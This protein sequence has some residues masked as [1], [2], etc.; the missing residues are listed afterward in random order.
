VTP[1]MP[2]ERPGPAGV[3]EALERAASILETAPRVAIACHVNPDPDAIG[4]MLGLA[5]ALRTRGTEV[6]CSWANDP[7][8][9]PAWLDL[10]GDVAP[11]V[12]AREF[13]SAPELMVTCDAASADRLGSLVASADRAGE[14][15]VIDHHVTNPGFGSVNLID[16]HAASS[17]E[18]VF[19]VVERMGLAL[20]DQT[21]A[22][23][24]AGVVTD[25]GRFQY[26]ATTGETLRVAAHLRDHGFDHARLAHALFEDGSFAGL[27][28]LSVALARAELV[29]DTRLGLVWTYLT[30]EDLA[31][32]GVSITETDDVIDVIRTAREA[33]VACVLKQQRD[34]RFKV[35]LRSRGETDVGAIAGAH[36]GGGHRLA[37]G[38][39]SRLGV[40]GTIDAIVA[41]LGP[42][43]A[44]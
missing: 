8:E 41:G 6:V 35:S 24:Y 26:E 18:V 9:R 11:I 30:Q 2:A 28:L 44:S 32:A 17:A 1:A 39:T 37:A 16:P 38:Y 12:H 20:S 40:R 36:G 14:V 5:G 34:G 29:P 15:I 21:A 33:D 43:A 31:R 7:M 19:R 4:S 25:T 10:V 3:D 27:G 42:R 22:C 23:L 13:P